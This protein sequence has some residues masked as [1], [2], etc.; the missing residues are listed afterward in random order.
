MNFR[1][2][3]D[4]PSVRLP[5][6]PLIDVIFLL[7]I[8][9]LTTQVLYRSEA[10]M[11]IVIPTADEATISAR[12]VGEIIINVKADGTIVLEGREFTLDELKAILKR[13]AG[14][15]KDTPVIVRGDRNT[16]HQNI[17]NVLDAC[18]VSSIRLVSFAAIPSDEE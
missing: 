9:F 3:E 1:K 10:E 13:L 14:Q 8:F 7:L 16:I 4:D 2:H 12:Q 6:T 11:D 18:S 5:M 17:M 15:F